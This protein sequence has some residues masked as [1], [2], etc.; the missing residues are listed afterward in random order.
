MVKPTRRGLM[1]AFL[2]PHL[3]RNIWNTAQ[4]RSEGSG[5]MKGAGSSTGARTLTAMTSAL[6]VTYLQYGADTGAPIVL[7][8]GWPYDVHCYDQV[9]PILAQA[10]YR[11]IVPYMRGFGPTR[12]RSESTMRSGQQAALGKDV[13]DLLDVLQ[14]K[15]ATLAGYDWGGRAACIVAA[16]WPKRVHA[17]VTATGYTI[18]DNQKNS[19]ELG[20]IEVA[21]K[22]WYRWL[23]NTPMGERT[24][25]QN[26]GGL[27]RKL[28][29]LWSPTRKFNESKF[30]ETLSS[31]DNP[32]WIPTTLHC[33]RHW[34][35]NTAGDPSL[36]SLEHALVV[37]PPISA[38]TMVLHGDSDSLYPVSASLGQ[39][40]LFLGPYERRILK[41]IGHCP[42]MESPDEF[43]QGILDLLKGL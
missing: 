22:S 2:M 23:L 39:E 35:A 1:T 14:I 37:K 8:H 43:S 9:G 27:A 12:Y 3:F 29:Q 15:T 38:P 4:R 11:V 33:Y 21:Y 13:V 7:L 34:Y 36:E 20:D 42:P 41:G 24:L 19:S 26:A 32:D 16:L 28:W 25:R 6:N 40:H 31:F 10:G 18:Y 17:L 30:A 5:G